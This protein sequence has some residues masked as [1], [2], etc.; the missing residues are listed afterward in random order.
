MPDSAETPVPVTPP[1]PCC[2][3]CRFWQ[4]LQD[5]NEGRCRRMPDHHQPRTE[6]AEWC[7]EHSDEQAKARELLVRALAP[8]PALT[9]AEVH[10]AMQLE[11]PGPVPEPKKK[12]R[13]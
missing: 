7:G 5:R 11:P 3:T 9:V 6:A 10:A 12:R 8:A 1:E 4:K 13:W 2:A